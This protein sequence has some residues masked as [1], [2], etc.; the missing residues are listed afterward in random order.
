VAG[1]EKGFRKRRYLLHSLR[2]E[3]DKSA[4]KGDFK[5][6]RKIAI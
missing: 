1:E 3:E 5:A 6:L 4:G 2:V